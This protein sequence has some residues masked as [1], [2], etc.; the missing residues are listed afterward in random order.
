MTKKYLKI[1]L[2]SSFIGFALAYLFV[3]FF[4]YNVKKELVQ[5]EQRKIRIQALADSYALCVGLYNANPSKQREELCSYIKQKV[6][7]E[8]KNIEGKYPYTSL[9]QKVFN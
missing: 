3:E 6:Y 2:I 8:V 1:V 5:Y 7:L 9:Y 4:S